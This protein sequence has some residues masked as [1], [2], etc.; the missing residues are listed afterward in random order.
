LTQEGHGHFPRNLSGRYRFCKRNEYKFLKPPVKT[1]GMRRVR[2]FL[3]LSQ[4]NVSLAYKFPEL[5]H[6]DKY[7]V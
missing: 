7:L 2:K 3:N 5:S 1:F 6:K 4:W